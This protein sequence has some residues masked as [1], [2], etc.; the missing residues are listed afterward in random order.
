M[1]DELQATMQSVLVSCLSSI[2]II[3]SRQITLEVDYKVH[4]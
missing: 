1:V 2:T 3:T 4:L